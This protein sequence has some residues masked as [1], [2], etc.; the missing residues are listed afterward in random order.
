ME[1]GFI[2]AGKMAEAILAG[3]L[4][5]QLCEAGTMM[6]SDV[7]ADR[8]HY[9]QKTYEVQPASGNLEVAA[10]CGT[11]IL[12]VKPQD[13]S[14]VLDEIEDVIIDKSVVSIAAGKTLALFENRVPKARWIRAMPN[15]GCQ[16][17]EG[18]T[19]VC[20]GSLATRYDID[21]VKSIF[22][23]CGKV[24]ELT[25]DEFDTV[26][27]LSGSGPAFFAFVVEALVEAAVKR[28]MPETVALEL[29]LQTMRGTAA[30]MQQQ[31]LA[32]SQFIKAVASKGGTTAAGLSVLETCDV[33]G[34]LAA[35]LQAA[36]ERS[37]SLSG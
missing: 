21:W 4:K 2:G 30:V 25:E 13:M 36:A 6:V 20:P 35:T 31:C 28:G 23:S 14:K 5:K 24:Q 37:E 32:P 7:S 16:A 12:A 29:A 15:L 11:L 26:T 19:V 18:M 27:A 9:M 1:I 22:Q 3:M 34:H 33:R 10:T 8:L 17:G